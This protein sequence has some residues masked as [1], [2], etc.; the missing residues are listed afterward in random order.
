MSRRVPCADCKVYFDP[1][2]CGKG[3]ACITNI[4]PDEVFRTVMKFV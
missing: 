3:F 2:E 4:T 1:E